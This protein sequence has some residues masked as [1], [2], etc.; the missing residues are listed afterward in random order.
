MKNY[1][2]LSGLPRSG[3]TLFSTLMSQHSDI[4]TEGNS[5]LCQ[6]MWDAKISC[7]IN[8]KETLVSNYKFDF[9]NNFISSIPQTYY[10]NAEKNIILDK[11]RSWTLEG[12][13][14]LIKN[15]ITE[16][17]KIIVL[18]RPINEILISIRNLFDKNNKPFDDSYYDDLL[19]DNSEPIIRSLHGII[20]ARQKNN[21]EF[22]FIS[23][24][25]LVRDTKNVIKNVCDFYEVSNFE[26]N[27]NKIEKKFNV[28]DKFLGLVGQHEVR[29]QISVNSY[30]ISLP[31]NIQ[32]KCD[33]LNILLEGI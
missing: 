2:F 6:L 1:I 31:K 12:N 22:L 14:N 11:C 17:P 8:C 33:D 23:Y 30:D 10:K 18:Y 21:K 16:T 28:D 26:V 27:L 4:H 7:E 24:D 15:Y 5:S 20:N 9:Q 32:K 3:S 29:E 13:L 19:K 25:K